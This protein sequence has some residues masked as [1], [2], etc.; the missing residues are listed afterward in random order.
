MPQRFIIKHKVSCETECRCNDHYWTDSVL[1]PV[2]KDPSF[3]KVPKPVGRGLP[4]EYK[5]LQRIAQRLRPIIRGS[6]VSGINSFSKNIDLNDL[7]DAISK[8][9]VAQAL[10][11]VPWDD[12]R[13]AIKGIDKA[14]LDGVSESAEQSKF[15]FRKSIQ[16]LIPSLVPDVVFDAANPR[17]QNWIENH[18][19]ELVQNIRT[20]TQ[21]GIQQ[22]ITTAINQGIP[23][24]DSAKLIKKIVGLNDRQVTAV[25]NRRKKLM[26]SGFKGDKLE[27]KIEA[28]TQKQLKYRSEMIART[29]TMTAN[30]QGQMEVM[31]QNADAGLF[32]RSK[33]KKKWIVTPYDRVCKICAPMHGKKVGLDEEFKLRDGKTVSVPPAHPNCNCSWSIDLGGAI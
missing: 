20:S 3:P 24:R 19:G 30:N 27:E 12:F 18:I 4:N 25:L 8:A 15:L 10:D 22:I 16:S 32:D 9:D 14:V 29:E 31:Q 21:N 26:E 17:I 5:A 6:L 7:A 1:D 2:N 23:P 33:A 11:V 13:G 28:Y